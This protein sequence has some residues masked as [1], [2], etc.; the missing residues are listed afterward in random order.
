MLGIA[1]GHI[2]S[3]FVK[4]LPEPVFHARWLTKAVRI[5]QSGSVW[6]ILVLNQITS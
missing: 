4:R 5:L 3:Q 2:D 6:F 1:A